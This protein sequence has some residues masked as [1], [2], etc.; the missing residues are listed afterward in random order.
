MGPTKTL[1]P[2]CGNC[3]LATMRHDNGYRCSIRIRIR[4]GVATNGPC[5][6]LNY[7]PPNASCAPRPYAAV[8]DCAMPEAVAIECLDTDEFPTVDRDMRASPRSLPIQRLTRP[9]LSQR[10][11]LT[12]TLP[13]RYLAA[14]SPWLIELPLPARSPEPM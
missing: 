7:S 10:F 13:D 4:Y 14:N 9:N 1:Q 12:K 5:Q 3:W 11:E 2:N 8:L 6:T